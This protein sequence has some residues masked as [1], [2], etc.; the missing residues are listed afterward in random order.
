MRNIYININ[1][2]FLG[3]VLTMCGMGHT[4]CSD[5]LEVEPQNIITLEQF[6]NEEQDVVNSIAGCYSTLESYGALSR[7]MV[8]G[9][10]RSDNVINRGTIVK[11]INL[12]R[13][14]KE[15]ITA[16][17][18][19]TAWNDFYT[20]I[21]RCNIIMHYAPEV[22]ASDPSY[23]QGE[24]K[25]HMAECTALRSLCYFYLIRTF[26][27]IPYSEEPYMDDA[28]TVDL[29]PMDFEVVLG[30]LIASLEAVKNDAVVYYP[31]VSGL[32][33][34]YQTSRITQLAIYAMLC[35]MYLWNKDYDKC[36]DCAEFVIDFKKKYIKANQSIPE[37][38]STYD[39]YPLKSDHYYGSSSYGRSYN[40][41]F[42]GNNSD[43]SI[44]ELA[45]V[46]RNNNLLSN[47]PV[48]NFYGNSEF[49]G[50]VKPSEY[51][52]GQ[53]QKNSN[54]TL[55][56]MYDGR[57]YENFRFN[58]GGE[59]QSINKY[60]GSSDLQ[61]PAP[62]AASIYSDALRGS[63]YPVE[64]KDQDS[65]NK[66]N[67]I[68][69]RLSDIM[70]LEAEA[71][72]AKIEAPEGVLTDA[73]RENLNKAFSLC[74]AVNKRSVY[75]ETLKDTLKA[76]DYQTKDKIM[77]LVYNERQRE[78]MFEGKRYYDLVRRSLRDGNSD[79]MRNKVKAKSLELSSVVENIFKSYPDALFWP[80]NLEETKVNPYLK[81][82]SAF[83]SGESGSI[84]KK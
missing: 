49:K 12:E 68:I 44:F 78:L 17:N 54:T 69:Y 20:V 58:A 14:L 77:D 21:N 71:L 23:T 30:K 65:R 60:T 16:T 62:N 4:S 26:R 24:L 40:D 52:E 10:F 83:G 72:S 8:W 32:A 84:S 3:F 48:S 45:F 70:L 43:E 28:Q 55:F 29:V 57:R 81:Q 53:A 56:N 15:N 79:Y 27:S 47:G 22:A 66:S 7:M 63:L 38:F 75:Q 36:I 33:G 67:W 76:G 74:N 31:R 59:V 64:G 34:N 39:G 42:V 19:Y 2:F 82:N 50:W 80:Y 6:W 13:V 18:S 11:D 61:L 41:L 5:F 73:D 25:A 9:E 37:D 51:L 46:K 35:E 1:K